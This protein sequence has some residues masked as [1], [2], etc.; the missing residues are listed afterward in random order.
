MFE[1][2]SAAG[3]RCE[4]RGDGEGPCGVGLMDE[5]DL[6]VMDVL[7]DAVEAVAEVQGCDLYQRPVSVPWN[8]IRKCNGALLV[9]KAW[10]GLAEQKKKEGGQDGGGI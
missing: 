3:G 1:A 5:I 10:L 2:S 6:T 4:S 8:V 7:V 9:H